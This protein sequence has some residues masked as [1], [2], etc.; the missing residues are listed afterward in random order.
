M[1][2]QSVDYLVDDLAVGAESQPHEV[3]V[4]PLHGPDHLAV[5][6]IVRGPEHVLGVDRGLDAARE[7]AIER[8]RECRPVG[9]V[10]QDRLADQRV[11]AVA[12]AVLVGMADTIREGS[13]DSA[14]KERRDIELL[15]RLKVVADDQAI[16]VSNCIQRL[17]DVAR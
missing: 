16:L 13:R 15:P 10:D 7:R 17:V 6:R 12:R 4:G 5:R 8:P 1:K 14:R 11:V 2:L 9:A 3:E